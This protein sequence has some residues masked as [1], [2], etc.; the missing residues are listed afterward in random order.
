MHVSKRELK[1]SSSLAAA[2]SGED[3]LDEFPSPSTSV[4]KKLKLSSTDEDEHESSSFSPS[5]T[6]DPSCPDPVLEAVELVPATEMG[7]RSS[8]QLNFF[9]Y[10]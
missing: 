2:L 10:I 7:S 5:E 4:S 6:S 1:V 3:L 8:H 9:S